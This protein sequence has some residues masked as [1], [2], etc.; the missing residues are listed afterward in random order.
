MF[1]VEKEKNKIQVEVNLPARKLAKDPCQIVDKDKVLDFLR[2]NGYSLEGYNLTTTTEC[3]NAD[4]NSKRHGIWVWE[5]KEV[6]KN[7]KTNTPANTPTS[8]PATKPR[9]RTRASKPKTEEG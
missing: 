3:R 9:N 7:V 5:K 6:I 2:E 4:E 1:K 8:K